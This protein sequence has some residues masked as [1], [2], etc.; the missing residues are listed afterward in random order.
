MMIFSCDSHGKTRFSVSLSWIIYQSINDNAEVSDDDMPENIEKFWI[1]K[2]LNNSYS[3]DDS[4]YWERKW[5][6]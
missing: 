3:S 1:G 5:T 6:W 4:L 2:D